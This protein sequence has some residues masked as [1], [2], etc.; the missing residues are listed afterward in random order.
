M[1]LSRAL[2]IILEYSNRS[3]RASAS[4]LH[5]DQSTEQCGHS[6]FPC[7]QGMTGL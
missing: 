5:S 1:S 7:L 2:S 4:G 6:M 3:D